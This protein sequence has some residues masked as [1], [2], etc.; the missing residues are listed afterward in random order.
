MSVTRSSSSVVVRVDLE[1][2]DGTQSTVYYGPFLPHVGGATTR[3]A[4]SIERELAE[5]DKYRKYEVSI[6]TVFIGEG[7]SDCIV[8]PADG[9]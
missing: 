8:R 5:S 2:V 6:E 9:S 3:F 7:E 4:D 1:R